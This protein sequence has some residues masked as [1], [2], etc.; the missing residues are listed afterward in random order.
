MLLG[1]C[2]A[3][4]DFNKEFNDYLTA[5]DLE[6]AGEVLNRWEG[7]THDDPEAIVGRFNLTLDQAHN[8]PI[9]YFTVLDSMQNLAKI[10][11]GDNPDEKVI[12][13]D[14]EWNDSLVNEAVKVIDHG[15]ALYPDRLDMRF[16]KATALTLIDDWEGL[17]RTAIDALEHARVNGCRWLWMNNEPMIDA[18]AEMLEAIH[19]YERTLAAN[20]HNESLLDRNIELY[21]TDHIAL[22]LKGMLAY[23]A[24]DYP[25]ALELTQ[26]AHRAAPDDMLIVCNLAYLNYLNNDKVTARALYQSVLDNPASEDQW[27]EEATYWLTKLADSE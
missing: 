5:G 9:L 6:R 17:S 18:E 4:Q 13:A 14:G 2:S 19:E 21:P 11:A 25:R 10:I 12:Y 24:K 20:T 7:A 8:E 27:R 3:A 23:E 15:I 16:G 22:T 1:F 26:R